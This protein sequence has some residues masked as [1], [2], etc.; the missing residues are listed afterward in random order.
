[1]NERQQIPIE[2]KLELYALAKH[3]F[4]EGY[5]H[6]MVM[7]RLLDDCSKEE[8]ELIAE[9]G[10]NE[11]W[12]KLY[13]SARKLYGDGKTYAEVIQSLRSLESDEEIVQYVANKWYELK[14]LEVESIVDGN[15]NVFDGLLWVGIGAVGVVSVFVLDGSRFS[16]IIWSAAFVVSAVQY[17]IGRHQRQVAGRIKKLMKEDEQ[18]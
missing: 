14:S 4:N 9:K 5:S 1:M 11:E 16:K 17:F 15:R 6:P 8:A 3:M 13:E 10:L 2:E 7:D 18:N 12:D